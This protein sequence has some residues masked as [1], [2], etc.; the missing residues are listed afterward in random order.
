MN[1]LRISIQLHETRYALEQNLRA[2]DDDLESTYKEFL[3]QAGEL[4]EMLAELWEHE[5]KKIE[6]N[7]DV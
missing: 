6:E 5:V 4:Y 1:L 2:Y 7:Q 3:N